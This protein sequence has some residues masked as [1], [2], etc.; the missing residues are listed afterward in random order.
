MAP[1]VREKLNKGMA[2]DLTPSWGMEQHLVVTLWHR[3]RQFAQHDL[4]VRID[5]VFILF[6]KKKISRGYFSIDS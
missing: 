1:Q 5:L 6:F 3:S 4:T 2:V